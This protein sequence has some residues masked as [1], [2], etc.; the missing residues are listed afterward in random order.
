MPEVACLCWTFPFSPEHVAAGKAWRLLPLSVYHWM[1]SSLGTVRVFGVRTMWVARRLYLFLDPLEDL[2]AGR[3]L[4]EVHLA[5]RV[6]NNLHIRRRSR[7]H[8]LHGGLGCNGHIANYL[9]AHLARL[10][11]GKPFH[12]VERRY[13][14]QEFRLQIVGALLLRNQCGFRQP[15][16]P[17]A[18]GI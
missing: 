3:R 17:I 13:L 12:W 18:P 8:R 15:F 5:V 11:L 16:R 14:L 2:I 9:Q 10:Q 7:H 4:L 6:A 1:V